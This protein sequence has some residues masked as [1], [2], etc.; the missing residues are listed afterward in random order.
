MDPSVLAAPFL[1][2]ERL[3]LMAIVDGL[4]YR[5]E[6]NVVLLLNLGRRQRFL[7]DGFAVENLGADAAVDEKLAVIRPPRFAC[8]N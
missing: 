3:V 6:G 1:V 2:Q 8:R 4:E 7:P 5:F